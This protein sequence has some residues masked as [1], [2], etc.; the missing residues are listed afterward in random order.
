VR[1]RISTI[2]EQ[3]STKLVHGKNVWRKKSDGMGGETDRT[4]AEIKT[5]FGGGAEGLEKGII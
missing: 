4:I 2:G 3:S 5:V 1:L